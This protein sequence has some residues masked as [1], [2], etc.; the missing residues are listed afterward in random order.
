MS[1][2]HHA[3]ARST[4]THIL[5]LMDDANI[6]ATRMILLVFFNDINR[7]IG[8]AVV[9]KEELNALECLC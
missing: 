6:L 7:R 5:W 2:I 4:N 1:F 9:T 8:T 3:V